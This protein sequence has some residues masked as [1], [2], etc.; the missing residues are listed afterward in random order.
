MSVTAWIAVLVVIATV[1][2]LIKRYETRL[3]L[4]TAGLLLCCISMQPMAALNQFAKSM[5]N[6]ALIMAIC[7]A[8]GFAYV[9]TH[10]QC[11]RHL[12]SLL[13]AP[14]KNWVCCLFRLVPLSLSSLTLLFLRRPDALLQ[15]VQLSFQ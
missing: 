5:T 7:G 2:C 14:L 8:M 10:T 12:V 4:F 9:I 3:V 6:S 13:A 1:Y 15:S 11:D